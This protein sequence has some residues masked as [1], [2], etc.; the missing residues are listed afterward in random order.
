MPAI[1]ERAAPSP[2]PLVPLGPTTWVTPA[3]MGPGL[4]TQSAGPDAHLFQKLPSRLAQSHV[5]PAAGHPPAR[6]ADIPDLLSQ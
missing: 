4:L 6:P 5:S 2:P 1:T 3:H